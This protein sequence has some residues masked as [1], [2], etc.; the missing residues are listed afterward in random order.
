MRVAEQA[1]S[2]ERR[3]RADLRLRVEGAPRVIQVRLARAREPAELARAQLLEIRLV[4]R[5]TRGQHPRLRIRAMA[6][7]VDARGASL[8]EARSA[9]LSSCGVPPKYR[10]MATARARVSAG[11]PGAMAG[12]ITSSS[13]S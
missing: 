3:V 8:L 6:S 7:A 1:A 11:V 2:H 13:Q 12:F 4:G 9:S 10:L 5:H